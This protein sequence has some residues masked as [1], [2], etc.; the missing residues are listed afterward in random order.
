[1]PELLLAKKQLLF[2]KIS[3]SARQLLAAI[4]SPFYS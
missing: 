4:L 1:M 2:S 3:F